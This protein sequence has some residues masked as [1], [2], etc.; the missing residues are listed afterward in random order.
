MKSFLNRIVGRGAADLGIDLAVRFAQRFPASLDDGGLPKVSADRLGRILEKVYFEAQSMRDSHGFGYLG[1][2]RLCHA[3]QWRMRELGYSGPIIDL[4]TEGLVVYLTKPQ[5]TQPEAERAQA[6]RDRK[7]AKARALAEQPAVDATSKLGHAGQ[8]AE[9]SRQ[10][11]SP[12]YLALT[13]LYRQMHEQGESFLNL[14]PEETFPGLSLPPQAAR[15]KRLIDVTQ[16]R[17]VL[18]YGCGK[19]LQYQAHDIS[20]PGVEGTWPSVQTYWSVESIHCYDPAYTPFSELPRGA[21]DGVISTDVLEHCPE[22]DMPWIL[23]EIFS[24]ARKFVFANV[25]CYPAKK[26]LP[27]GENAHCTIKP[28][29]WWLEQVGQVA[30]KH[31]GIQY[32]IWVQWKDV[33]GKLVEDVISST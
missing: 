31:P 12:R 8:T 21:F 28:M 26:R 16:T 1:R 2:V 24:Y 32:E 5:L 7:A 9:P 20:I 27:T 25:A 19:G 30:S 29:E 15:I 33:G 22:E 14:K 17:R 10:T 4:A 13:T 3:F 18:D 11:P 23:N 6:K